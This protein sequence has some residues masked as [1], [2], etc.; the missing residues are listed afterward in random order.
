MKTAV[1]IG[2]ILW[3]IIG[4]AEYLGGAP[5]NCAVHCVALG[6]EA[7]VVSR[8]GTDARGRAALKALSQRGVSTACVSADPARPTGTALVFPERDGADRFTLPENAAYDFAALSGAE[9]SDIIALRPDAL[10]YGTLAP[11]RSKSV[12]AALE[13]LV[14][15]CVQN[16]AEALYDVNL[17]LSY[18][19]AVL[20]RRLLS[21]CTVLKLN[22]GE[23]SVLSPLLFGPGLNGSGFS[24]RIFAEYPLC[25]CIVTTLGENGAECATRSGERFAVPG[26]KVDVADTVGAGDAFSAAFLASYLETH[27]EKASLEAGNRAGAFTASQPGATPEYPKP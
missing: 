10:V 24:S 2:E 1:C 14:P 9:I 16:G 25:R 18:Y 13:A 20:V 17:R 6:M 22:D 26:I 12:L 5:L 3:D 8:V 23:L 4:E 21:M 27:D 19:D 11:Y 7:R 15:A